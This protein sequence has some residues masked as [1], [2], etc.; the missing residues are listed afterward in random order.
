MNDTSIS[1]LTEKIYEI[2]IHSEGDSVL[3]RSSCHKV[4]DKPVK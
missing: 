1:T 3:S 4:D 2:P